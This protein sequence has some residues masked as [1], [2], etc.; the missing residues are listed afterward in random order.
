MTGMLAPPSVAQPVT[1]TQSDIDTGATGSF[2]YTAGSPPTYTIQGAGTGFPAGY[3]DS[4]SFVSTAAVGNIEFECEVSSQGSTGSTAQAG[5]MIRMST[6][7]PNSPVYAIAVTPSSGVN[8]YYRDVGSNI[9]TVS[10]PAVT[11]PVYLR[12]VRSGNTIS[13]YYSTTGLGN[14]TLVGSHTVS[15]IIIPPLYF[16]GFFVDSS[17]SGTL[18]TSV[19]TDVSYM[20]SVPQPSANLLQWLRA[21]AGVTSSSGNVSTWSDQ[22]GNGNDATQST[23]ALQ[24]SLVAGTI[25]NAVLPTVTFDGSSQYM[26]SASDFANLTSGASIF[27]VINPTSSVATGTPCAYGNASNSD[28]IF[29]QTV[30]TQAK[31]NVYNSSTASSVTTTDN[32]LSTGSYQL[33]EE[34]FAPGS[35]TG[36]GTVYVNGTQHVQ[37]TS[38]VQTMTNTTRSSNTLGV[39]IGLSNY[40]QGGIA[41]LLVYSA[42]LTASQRASVESYIYSK[43]AIGTEPTLD[44][45]TTS[46]GPGVFLPGPGAD[47]P[48]QY[49]TPAQDQG[50][51]IFYTTDG[52]TPSVSSSLH[53][54]GGNSI[55][56]D[57]TRTMKFLA[58]EPFFNN[59]SV[60]SVLFQANN[61]T[62][63]IPR[64]GLMLWLD[65]NNSLTL[66]GSDVTTWAD[67]S[68]SQNNATQ[69]TSLDQPTL[70]TNAINGLPAVAFNGSSQFLQLPAGFANFTS[71]CSIFVV[72]NPTTVSTGARFI[73]FGNGSA[74]NN[75][76][77][78]EPSSSGAALYV[79]NGSSPTNVTS[80]SAITL[81]QFQLLEAVHNGTA[82]ATIS[83]NGV[84]GA[85]NNSMNSINNTSRANNYIGQGSGGGNYFQGQIAEILVYNRAVT[86]SEQASIEGYFLGKYQ[87]LPLVSIAAPTI[88]VAAGT[89]STPTQV[90]I[91]APA[92]AQIFVTTDGT[93]PTTSSPPYTGPIN[94]SYS[95]TV[96]AIA[97]VDGV[98]SSVASAAYTLDS[99]LYPAPNSG[100]TTPLQINTQ[101]PVNGI[102]QDS[103]QH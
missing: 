83:T 47:L 80:S 20:S 100:D 94:V 79:Y 3:T 87:I 81:N 84:F 44:A 96:K 72:T 54:N 55:F 66:S 7:D 88:S 16:A 71:G 33:L 56:L 102:P 58:Y 26:S 22:S 38:M 11:A 85:Q 21:D 69:S 60:L 51:A 18:N 76:L 52:T 67:I 95:Q 24:P 35:S 31:L 45:P 30:G 53:Y 63:A 49:I 36:T 27:A 74:S 103:N 73:D 62:N 77:L 13:G 93:T 15:T 23:G 28:A 40:F 86:A 10:G 25:N 46:P 2:T 17:V 34:T 6:W 32:P 78:D 92:N 90:A 61:N 91:E 9:T 68:G 14:W 4:L 64:S 42:P 12:L 57:Q 50:G 65:A 5:L 99:T 75:V 43:Y 70:V 1:Y 59:S 98:S 101:L 41:E 19:F 8:F 97:V 89:L 29:P 48:G 82:S 39:G 37:S